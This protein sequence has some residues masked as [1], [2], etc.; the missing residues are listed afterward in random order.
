MHPLQQTVLQY[1]LCLFPT[2]VF[3]HFSV[4]NYCF[5]KSIRE[6]IRCVIGQSTWVSGSLSGF[7]TN[8]KPNW[9]HECTARPRGRPHTHDL[10]ITSPQ[11]LCPPNFIF[12]LSCTPTKQISSVHP[13]LSCSCDQSIVCRGP[14]FFSSLSH[15]LVPF[16]LSACAWCPAGV[17]LS[18]GCN[19]YTREQMYHSLSL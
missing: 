9:K 3:L 5:I 12:I 17:I 2:L 16:C 15:T 7:I 1:V 8:I 13:P 4:S 6:T 11:S 10:Q 19:Q 14:F 18:Q